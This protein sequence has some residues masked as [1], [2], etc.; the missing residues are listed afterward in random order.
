[1][2]NSR[3]PFAKGYKPPVT[4]ENLSLWLKQCDKVLSYVLSLKD[5]RQKLLIEGCCKTVIWG[6]TF[7]IH[8][9][10]SI[11]QE[12]LSHECCPLQYIPTYKFSQGHI[13]LLFNKVCHRCGWN[14]IPYVLQLL[15]AL[16]RLFIRNSIEPS[17]TGNCTHF[18]NTLCEPNRLFDFPS[19]WNQH[20][21]TTIDYNDNEE[22]YSCERMLLQFDQEL[23]NEL[24]DNVLYYISEFVIRVLITKLE[25][26]E[27]IG[28]L[29][30]DPQDPHALKVMDYPIHVKSTCF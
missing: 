28:E 14:N 5:Q 29:L 27:C 17:N 25:C 8:P 19:K 12:Y 16:K 7:S 21:E 6:F 11:A 2:L 1:M 4:K 3:N 18:D 13:E 9:L 20:Q 26:M 24:Q 15:Y 30:L 23:P 10:V 22:N